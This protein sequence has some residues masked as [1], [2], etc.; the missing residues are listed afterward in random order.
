MA[1][2]ASAPTAGTTALRSV[3]T[4]DRARL[5][6]RGAAKPRSELA[7]ALL[8]AFSTFLSPH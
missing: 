7:A 3:A 2:F 6:L 8:G 4:G 1:R 5:L